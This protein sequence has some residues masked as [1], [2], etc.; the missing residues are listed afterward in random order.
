MM[1][2]ATLAA[3]IWLDVPFIRQ[4]KNGCG[5]AAVA[6]VFDYWRHPHDGLAMRTPDGLSAREM[7]AYFEAHGFQA[8]PVAAE[9]SDLEH[10][11]AQG[12]PLIVALGSG[13]AGLQHFVV[14]AGIDTQR[15][16]VYV[17][18]PAQR[19]LVKMERRTFEREW[20]GPGRWTLLAVPG[21]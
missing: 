2:A 4:D 15:G 5:P 21:P 16:L 6:M 10:H 8:F 7:Q 1:L 12:R 18:D 11:L 9:W 19:K 20:R 3:A 13:G 17:N 14:V